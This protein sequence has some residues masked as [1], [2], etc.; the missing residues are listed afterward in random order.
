M[1]KDILRTLLRKASWVVGFPITPSGWNCTRQNT[2]LSPT[3]LY[4]ARQP[5]CRESTPPALINHRTAVTQPFDQSY[6]SQGI[7]KLTGPQVHFAWTPPD[8]QMCSTSRVLVILRCSPCL[9]HSSH[10]LKYRTVARWSAKAREA[11]CFLLAWLQS[12]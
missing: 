9:S 10:Q 3:P 1:I 11:R 6:P 4:S 8:S 7:R 2:E 12:N 5:A